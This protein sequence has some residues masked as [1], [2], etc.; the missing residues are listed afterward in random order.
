MF[1]RYYKAPA[2]KVGD[3]ASDSHL[4]ICQQG[5][6]HFQDPQ[7]AEDWCHQSTRDR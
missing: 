1:L 6:L 3:I 4:S 7:L 5:G 2:Q